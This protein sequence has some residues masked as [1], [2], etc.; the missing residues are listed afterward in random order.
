MDP[1]LDALQGAL[2]GL[3][4]ALATAAIAWLTLHVR[5]FFQSK[6][7]QDQRNFVVPMFTQA[8][9]WARK[10]FESGTP[11]SRE[12][13]LSKAVDYMFDH[14]PDALKALKLDRDSVRSAL[15]AR[16]S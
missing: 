2:N 6:L 1:A 5:N 3:L 16:L 11:P 7:N 10:Q 4:T 8:L 9:D 12:A 14:A 13:I 15:S